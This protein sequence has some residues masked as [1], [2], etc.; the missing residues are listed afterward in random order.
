MLAFNKKCPCKITKEGHSILKIA[1]CKNMHK[2]RK[3]VTRP[4]SEFL[5]NRC[6]NAW[7]QQRGYVVKDV[8]LKWRCKKVSRKSNFERNEVRSTTAP[9]E[10][11]ENLVDL[12]WSE[13]KIFWLFMLGDLRRKWNDRRKCLTPAPDN[14]EHGRQRLKIVHKLLL[15]Q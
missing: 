8:F 12:H 10:L 7:L 13:P 1:N 15:L 3:A 2:R 6:T 4:L 14:W 9:P 11:M 5:C